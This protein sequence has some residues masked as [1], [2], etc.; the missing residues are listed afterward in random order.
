[1]SF[2]ELIL[3]VAAVAIAWLVFTG[4]VKIAKTTI[5]TALT[6][7]AIVLVLQLGFGIA[8][9]QVGQEIWQMGQDLWN[10]VM[11]KR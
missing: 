2:I 3:L 7:A 8:P 6:V 4:L 5:T 11:G 1:M 9:T 10:M